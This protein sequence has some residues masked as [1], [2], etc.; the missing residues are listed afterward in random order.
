LTDVTY[1]ALHG[2]KSYL[3]KH[4]LLC[5][6]K[7]ITH[8]ALDTRKRFVSVPETGCL[9]TR[10][11]HIVETAGSNLLDALAIP[12]TEWRQVCTNDLQQVWNVLGKHAMEAVLFTEYRKELSP[13]GN[14]VNDHHLACLCDFQ[15][16]QSAP[17]KKL[18][19][20]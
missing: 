3:E 19:K 7:G 2:V 11:D 4:I 1:H 17:L 5:G 16:M 14:K 10:V 6:M 8:A 18:W 12:N 9:E 15:T 13:D 20:C